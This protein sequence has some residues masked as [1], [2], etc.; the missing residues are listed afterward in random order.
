MPPCS[1]ILG[2]ELFILEAQHV[3]DYEA[4]L[5]E[6]WQ[7]GN[8]EA[9]KDIAELLDR[10][11]GRIGAN[12]I[13]RFLPTEH[14]WPERSVKR[15]TSLQEQPK[16][17]WQI[18]KQ[19][20]VLL[21]PHPELIEVMVPLPDYPPLMFHYKGKPHRIKKADGPERIEREWWL[22]D[23]EHRDYYCVEDEDGGRYWLFRLGSYANN[24]PQWF[25]HGFFA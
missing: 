2:F 22:E 7:I 8:A 4:A 18:N 10:I 3:Q 17:E 13:H 21:L 14:Y 20:P 19:R 25:L 16:T 23:G 24:N 5:E 6:L 12:A 9:E 15:A 11:A 1:P